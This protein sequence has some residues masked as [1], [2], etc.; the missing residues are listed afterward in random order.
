MEIIGFCHS[1]LK[2]RISFHDTY[3]TILP[4]LITNDVDNIL[5]VGNDSLDGSPAH[6]ARDASSVLGRP[7]CNSLHLDK[8]LMVPDVLCKL[9][10]EERMN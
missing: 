6:Q 4:F 3:F 10:M 9:E 2:S 5:Q 7:S 8:H 1:I